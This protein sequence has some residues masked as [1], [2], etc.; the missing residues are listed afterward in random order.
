LLEISI[1]RV[2]RTGSRFARH[3]II[4]FTHTQRDGCRNPAHGKRSLP[5]R[6]ESSWPPQAQSIIIREVMTLPIAFVLLLLVS[7]S[8]FSRA[9]GSPLI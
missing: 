2:T 7:R 9:S 5:A 4:G 8:R 6:G 3:N 1:S